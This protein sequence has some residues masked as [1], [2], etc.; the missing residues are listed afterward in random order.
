MTPDSLE[1]ALRAVEPAHEC[2][3]DDPDQCCYDSVS[4]EALAA[5]A[6]EW[7]KRQM[8]QHSLT[9]F[10]YGWALSD[11]ERALGL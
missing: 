3:R 10:A 8:P 6:R 11:V 4:S 1:A 9:G 2:H 5:T 7:M